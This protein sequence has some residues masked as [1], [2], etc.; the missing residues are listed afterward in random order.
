M[1]F[2]ALSVPPLPSRMSS[3]P[4]PQPSA[5]PF[6][7]ALQIFSA[8]DGM[9][10][11]PWPKTV[12]LPATRLPV[13]CGGTGTGVLVGLGTGVA[14][15]VGAAERVAVGVLVGVAVA[16]TVVGGAVAGTF[17]GVAVAATVVGVAVAGTV[18]GVAVAGTVVG[19]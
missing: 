4:G 13:I 19:V 18:V 10:G 17:D 8:G 6:G 7:P 11:A 16:G 2:P 1:K 9:F 14:L 5:I 3:V 12:V 15:L